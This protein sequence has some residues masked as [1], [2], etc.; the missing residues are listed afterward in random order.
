MYLGIRTEAIK[1]R[2]RKHKRDSYL[3]GLNQ[4]DVA[5]RLG[6]TSSHIITEVLAI[7]SLVNFW[8]GDCSSVV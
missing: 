8:M 1:R 6:N 2:S 7:L 3:E 4:R 5:Y